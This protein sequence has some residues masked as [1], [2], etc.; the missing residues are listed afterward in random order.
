MHHCCH[1][2]EFYNDYIFTITTNIYTTLYAFLVLI[3]ILLLPL[4]ELP[5]VF[6]AKQLCDNE[7]P[8]L[9]FG[10]IFIPPSFLKDNFPKYRLLG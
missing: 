3:S 4:K 2:A 9:I 10:Q 8:H 7:L 5:F 6:S 1:I